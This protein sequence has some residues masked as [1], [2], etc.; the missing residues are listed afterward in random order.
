[1][2]LGAGR[3][4]GTELSKLGGGSLQWFLNNL[5]DLHLGAKAAFEYE[6]K[7]REETV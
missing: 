4:T 7:R 5:T 2:R 1:M 6:L 3:N